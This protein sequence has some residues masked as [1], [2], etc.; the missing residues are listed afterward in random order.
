MK[1]RYGKSLTR[2]N[3]LIGIQAWS[4]G[5]SIE[6]KKWL[7]WSFKGH[8][9]V[10]KEGF[11]DLFAEEQEGENYYEVVQEKLKEERFF[12]ELCNDFLI[13]VK[14][15]EEIIKKE[16]IFKEEIIK[17]YNLIIKCW[18]ALTIFDILSNYP[19]LASQNVIEKL[20]RIRKE[21]S[22]FIY[23]SEDKLIKSIL[24]IYP[25]VEEDINYIKIEEFLEGKFPSKQDLER[26]RKHYILS[27]E[28]FETNKSFFELSK[29]YD[30]EIIE[31]EVSDQIKGIVVMEGM[32]KG[33]VKI[34]LKYEDTYKVERG[35]I[36]VTSMTT[37]DYIQA[38]DK[39][40][41]FIT[42]EGGITCHAAIV[43]REFKKPCIIGT[44]NATKVLKD[45]D[46]V[47][48]NGETGVVER[49]N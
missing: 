27:N 22:K 32:V 9:F 33:K 26:R 4:F 15:S 13:N 42:D 46:L 7:D 49:I 20:I 10:N 16:L 41:A 24:K 29:E 1:K 38:M 2:E 6:L 25:E 43:A 30:F 28:F 21:T 37:P 48:V 47:L 11:V 45:G 8:Y 36:I 23:D 17:L 44:K 5:D 18:P 12:D 35:D 19:E 40:A 3:S 34:I 39:A 14:Q 31:E